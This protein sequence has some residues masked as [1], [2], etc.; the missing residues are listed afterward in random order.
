MSNIEVGF[1]KRQYPSPAAR[2]D[3]AKDGTAAGIFYVTTVG[4][5]F[6]RPLQELPLSAG[7]LP[8]QTHR[9][10]P[11]GNAPGPHRRLP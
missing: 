11:P 4:V 10:P 2:E 6:I 7:S 8:A 3:A 9:P 1:G 5:E